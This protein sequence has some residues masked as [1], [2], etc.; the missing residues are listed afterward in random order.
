MI[1]LTL[2]SLI[3]SSYMVEQSKERCLLT[4]KSKTM[5][6]K[7]RNLSSEKI[8]TTNHPHSCDD[9]RQTSNRFLK[10]WKIRV[11]LLYKIIFLNIEAIGKFTETTL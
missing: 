10:F 4:Y 7:S 11:S 6:Q 2:R 3:N 1:V 8:E 9:L 5:I